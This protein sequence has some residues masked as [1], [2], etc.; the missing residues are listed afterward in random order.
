MFNFKGRMFAF[1][2]AL[3]AVL[4]FVLGIMSRSQRAS[5]YRKHIEDEKVK[6]HK[7]AANEAFKDAKTHIKK[8]KDLS[9]KRERETSESEDEAIMKW[10]DDRI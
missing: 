8:A 4:G 9:A 1:G 3:L 5:E 7:K 10:N 2:A 6:M